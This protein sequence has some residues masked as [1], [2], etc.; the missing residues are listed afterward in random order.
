MTLIRKLDKDDLTLILESIDSLNGGTFNQIEH[1]LGLPK[2]LLSQILT[3]LKFFKLIKKPKNERKFYLDPNNYELWNKYNRELDYLVYSKSD[4][5][6]EIHENHGINCD[7]P[8]FETSDLTTLEW[9]YDDD[10]IC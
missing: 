10:E 6:K 9:G 5:A 4:R 3:E 8:D 2:Y 7:V 1:I